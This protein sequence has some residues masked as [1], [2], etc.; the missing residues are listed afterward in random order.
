MPAGKQGSRTQVWLDS[1]GDWSWPGRAGAATENLPPSW[2]PAFPPRVEHVAAPAAPVSWP[3][4]RAL[5]RARAMLVGIAAATCATIALNGPLGLERAV[6]LAGNGSE[7]A[8][9]DARVPDLPAPALAT[10]SEVSRD[11]AGSSIDAAS[12]T[13]AALHGQGAF[14][15]YLPAG[16]AS[17]TT[18]YPVLYL[19]H[20]DDQPD[21]A[22]LQVGLQGTLDRL[23]SR[24]AIPPLIAVM[25]QGGPGPNNWRDGA[26]AHYESYVLEV[27][28]LV[29][30]TLPTI[31]AR[32]ARAIAGDS[33]GGYGAMN[34]AL[35]NPYRY[36]VAESWLGFFNGLQG[37]LRRD[38]AIFSHLGL[39]AL[40]YG[41][42]SDHIANPAE[43]LP[44]AAALRASGARADGAIYPGE[45]SLETIEAHLESAL[46]FAGRALA[47][48]SAPAA[49]AVR[50]AHTLRASDARPASAR[51]TSHGA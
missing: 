13:S 21:S 22:F 36:S 5:P 16:Y 33:M 11:A 1:L 2:V 48:Q 49:T 35:S 9:P 17:T 50:T 44:F 30:A 15:V 3:R 45:H 7:T 39:S 46:A 6:G 8:V 34:I 42:E 37:E 29:D 41:A 47:Q 32:S 26:A 14:L 28:Q 43:D 27:Q 40:V 10:L 23:I 4:Q 20:G 12:Y 18:R 51:D 31:A 25:I 24:Q 38:R 19:L